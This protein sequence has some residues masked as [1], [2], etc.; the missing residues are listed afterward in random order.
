MSFW[1]ELPYSPMAADMNRFLAA[2]TELRF[3]ERTR[4]AV[5][6][7]VIGRMPI[8]TGRRLDQISGGDLDELLEACRQLQRADR[9]APD[10]DRGRHRHL[11]GLPA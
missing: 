5:G 7:Q 11:R 9:A 6:L 4:R 1:R 3:T 2:A 8:Q 10:A